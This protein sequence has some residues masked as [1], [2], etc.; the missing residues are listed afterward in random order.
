LIL[1]LSY[2]KL[3]SGRQGSHLHHYVH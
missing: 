3:W 1:C 2:H